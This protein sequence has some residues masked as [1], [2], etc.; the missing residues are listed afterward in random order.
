M[1]RC[2][3]AALPRPVKQQRELQV[4][5][6][7][8]TAV[9]VS[10]LLPL[11]PLLPPLAHCKPFCRTNYLELVFCKKLKNISCEYDR[12]NGCNSTLQAAWY[13]RHV[14]WTC[15]FYVSF[16]ICFL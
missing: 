8:T 11:P 6:G 16:I 4:R 3:A 14:H 15:S 9:I 13:I 1:P 10:R 7:T 5:E 2:R 12:L